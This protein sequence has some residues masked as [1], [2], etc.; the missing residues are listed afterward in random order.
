MLMVDEAHATGVF[1]PEG[2]GL[3]SALGLEDRVDVIMGTYSKALGGFGAYAAA[4]E[5]VI[6][7]F[8]NAARG[9]IYSTAL[10][11]CVIASDLAAL[12]ICAAGGRAGA[13]LLERASRFRERLRMQGRRV[14]GESQIVPVVVGDSRDAARLS[15]ALLERGICAAAIRP[16]TV[17]K[18]SARLRFSLCA[19][20]TDDD[21]AAALEAMREL[22]HA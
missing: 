20:H 22:A 7:Y 13:D 12:R 18:G 14:L 5:T 6:R 1:G 8:V 2:R 3:V 9:F 11:A 15:G 17:P 10:P 21:L 4:S 19:A 16:P